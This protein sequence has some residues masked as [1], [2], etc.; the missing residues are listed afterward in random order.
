MLNNLMKLLAKDMQVEGD[1]GSGIPGS[2]LIPFEEDTE[3]SIKE[4]NEGI[5]INCI[6]CPI[7]GKKQENFFVQALLGDLFGQGTMGSVLG[8]T[9]DGKQL[10]LWRDFPYSPDYKEFK[11]N[12][13]D[14]LNAVDFWR[15]QARQVEQS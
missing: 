4:T 7:P 6:I 1:F 5:V 12:L 8:I 3:V 2:Y 14:F 13:E 11:N 10:I 9:D 15:D